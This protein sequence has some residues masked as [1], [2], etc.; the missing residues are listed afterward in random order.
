MNIFVGEIRG[1]FRV[2]DAFIVEEEKWNKHLTQE[3]N[4]AKQTP[5]Y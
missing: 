3:G 4:R 1:K 5:K 2:R